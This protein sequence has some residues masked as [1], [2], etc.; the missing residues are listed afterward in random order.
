MIRFLSKRFSTRSSFGSK[1]DGSKK[2]EKSEEIKEETK[3]EEQGGSSMLEIA[4]GD[5]KEEEEDKETH[6]EV[7]GVDPKCRLSDIKRA[8]KRLA[9]QHYPDRVEPENRA[10]SKVRFERIT[11]AYEVLSDSAKRPEYDKTLGLDNRKG[12]TRPSDYDSERARANADGWRAKIR[13]TRGAKRVDKSHN[14]NEW[15]NLDN[16]PKAGVEGI[17]YRHCKCERQLTWGNA[18]KLAAIF[19][20]VAGIVCAVYFLD[21]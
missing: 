8:Y 7:L 11:E 21:T 15:D 12:Y 6:Y 9:L 20:F 18:A 16:D 5:E 10:E 2:G 13:A 1:T 4:E 19:I 17:N 14:F 3:D